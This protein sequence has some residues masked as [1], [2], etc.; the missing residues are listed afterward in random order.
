MFEQRLG[1]RLHAVTEN[2][3]LRREKMKFYEFGQKE[4]PVI[5]L[6]PGTCCHWK[7]NFSYVIDLLKKDFYVV[8][9][10]YDGFDETE[11]SE[12]SDMQSET[13]KIELYIKKQFQGNI[14]AIYGCSLGGSFVGLLMQRRRI[15]MN[16]GII[17]SSDLDEVSKEKAKLQTMLIIPLFYKM[18]HS[19]KI[20]DF[21]RNRMVKRGGE[22]YVKN[23]LRMMGIG[24]VDMSFV[25]KNSMKNQFYSDLITVLGTHME[26]KETNIHCFFAAKMGDKYKKRY[27]K[28]FANPHIVEHDLLHEELLV[29]Y[30]EEWVNDVKNCI[31]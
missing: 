12:F 31:L 16:H 7:N 9:V 10:S 17:G 23:G 8:C 27:L 22:G 29:R 14:H 24:G 11:K 28:H 6:L 2:C 20:P 30:P 13:V 1:I 18:L 4:N 15:H 19:G 3:Y 26:V 21:I 5:M 25:S